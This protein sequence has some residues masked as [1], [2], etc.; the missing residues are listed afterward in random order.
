MRRH[1]TPPPCDPSTLL[2]EPCA[3][4]CGR[5]LH[6]HTNQR[7][8]LCAEGHPTNGGRGL[9]PSCRHHARRDGDLHRY[10]TST[11]GTSNAPRPLHVVQALAHAL[12]AP[13]WADE[14]ACRDADPRQFFFDE[15]SGKTGDAVRQRLVATAQRYCGHCPVIADC[16][17]QADANLDQGLFGGAMRVR[18]NVSGYTWRLLTPAAPEPRPARRPTGVNKGRVA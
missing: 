18:T 14:A 6:R 7:P 17:V 2:D 3:G 16:A 12:V 5:R 1:R 8:I 4:R 10:P 13:R 9:C 15:G 11:T